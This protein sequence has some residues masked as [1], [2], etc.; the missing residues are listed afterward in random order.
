[1]VDTVFAS[2]PS[3][4]IS[5]VGADGARRFALKIIF[6]CSLGGGGGRYFSV[7]FFLGGWVF[8]WVACP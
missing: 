2:F 3:I 6:S 8:R 5:T 1:M 7:P 4:S